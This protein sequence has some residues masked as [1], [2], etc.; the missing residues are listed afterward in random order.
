VPCAPE[1]SEA[2]F[3]ESNCTDDVVLGVDPSCL[4]S[5]VGGD[6][7][8]GRSWLQDTL[9]RKLVDFAWNRRFFYLPG[10]CS[11]FF[12]VNPANSFNQPNFF[13]PERLF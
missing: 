6:W 2:A 9:K 7:K 12:R 10:G 11:P 3:L 13:Y 1:E 8:G 4:M 5:T